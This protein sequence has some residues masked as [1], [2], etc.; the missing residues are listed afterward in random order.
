MYQTLVLHD[1]AS[2]EVAAA[3]VLFLSLLITAAWLWKLYR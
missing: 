1:G 3:I 2:T